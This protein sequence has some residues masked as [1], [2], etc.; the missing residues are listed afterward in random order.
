MERDSLRESFERDDE[1]ERNRTHGDCI[2][3]NEQ[4]ERSE[5]LVAIESVEPQVRPGPGS[6]TTMKSNLK[7]KLL[8]RRTYPGSL[9]ELWILGERGLIA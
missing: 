7:S 3:D 5:G 1:R 8:A 4:V 2:V 9:S 6:R